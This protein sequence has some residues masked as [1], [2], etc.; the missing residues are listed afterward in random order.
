MERYSGA[1]MLF[2]TVVPLAWC[3]PSIYLHWPYL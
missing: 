2:F 3:V 1:I